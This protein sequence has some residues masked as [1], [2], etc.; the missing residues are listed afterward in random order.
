MDLDLTWALRIAAQY[1]VKA[2]ITYRVTD[3][4]VCKLDLYRPLYPSPSKPTLMFI[5]GGGW[6][7]EF[8]KETWSLWFLPFLQLG[9]DVANVEFTP[10]EVAPAPAAIRRAGGERAAGGSGFP[11]ENGKEAP[12]HTIV[13]GRCHDSTL[14]LLSAMV[15]ICTFSASMP[16]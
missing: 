11:G 14:Y 7:R 9:W 2:A 12:Y 10:G 1:D 4:F 6:S 16:Y 8:T 15:Q 13:R 5:H 3:R